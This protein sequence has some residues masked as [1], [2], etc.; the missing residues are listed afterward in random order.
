MRGVDAESVMRDLVRIVVGFDPREAIAYHVF[1]QSVLEKASMPVTFLPLA[2][3]SL[4]GYTEQHKDGSNRFTYSRFLTPHLMEHEGWAL[5]AD[6]DMVCNVDIAELWRL[7]DPSKA[8]QV[9]KHDYRT[10]AV[11]KYLGNKNEDY[12]RKNW[13]SVVLW[14]CGHP[15]NRCLTPEFVASKDGAFLHRFSWLADDA[16]G[17]LPKAWN[18]LAIEYDE[19]PSARLIHYTLGT[20]CFAEYRD[21]SSSVHWHQTFGRAMKGM[22]TVSPGSTPD[23]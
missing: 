23:P 16:I 1:C 17:E 11:K 4:A 18:W 20:P 10:K 7:R 9:V 22:E 2:A 19:D 3:Q 14:N 5:F 15:A 13:S 12:P 8:V 6:G 21:T